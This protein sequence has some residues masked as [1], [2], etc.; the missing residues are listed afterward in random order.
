MFNPRFQNPAKNEQYA[1]PGQSAIVSVLPGSITSVPRTISSQPSKSIAEGTG[2]EIPQDDDYVFLEVTRA[3]EPTGIVLEALAGNTYKRI[4]FFH[5][6]RRETSEDEKRD[7]CWSAG[8]R[9][10]SWDERLKECS[11]TIE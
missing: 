8:E 2:K 1:Q 5:L 7:G 6:G 4:G 10:W 11:L 3:P 9:D